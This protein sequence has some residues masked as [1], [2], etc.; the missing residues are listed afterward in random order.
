MKRI[1]GS[2]AVLFLGC[3]MTAYGSTQATTCCKGACGCGENA[4]CTHSGHCDDGCKGKDCCGKVCA[5]M[6][7]GKGCCD[8]K[9]GAKMC[10][11]MHDGKDCGDMC[12]QAKH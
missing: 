1:F 12:A 5:K 11:Q 7:D 4:T 3:V 10:A 6:H 9:D 2:L 8:G